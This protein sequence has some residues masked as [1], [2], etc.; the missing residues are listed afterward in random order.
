MELEEWRGDKG[1]FCP[2][3]DSSPIIIYGQKQGTFWKYMLMINTISNSNKFDF[4][5]FKNLDFLPNEIWGLFLLFFQ[6]RCQWYP[7]AWISVPFLWPLMG[8]IGRGWWPDPE[9][10]PRWL[11]HWAKYLSGKA[12]ESVLLKSK[13]SLNLLVHV[14]AGGAQTLCA[15]E[16]T[17]NALFLWTASWF[18]IF[19][20][21]HLKCKA[22]S[23]SSKPLCSGFELNNIYFL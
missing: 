11:L 6:A 20:S 13:G 12:G 10:R 22:T 5:V 1:N 4:T 15:V 9:N 23:Y 2:I 16:N 19:Q 18:Y 8:G 21:H 3:I 14:G 7:L 17:F